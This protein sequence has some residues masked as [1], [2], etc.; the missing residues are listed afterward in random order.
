MLKISNLTKLYGEKK[1]VDNLTL[2]I[3]SGEIYGLLNVKVSA[4]EKAKYD[5]K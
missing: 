4:L 2:H 1:A 3:A 5:L